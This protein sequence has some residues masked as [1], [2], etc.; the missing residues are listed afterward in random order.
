MDRIDLV[1]PDH[2]ATPV[3]NTKREWKNQ[4][5]IAA[6]TNQSE[7]A[8]KLSQNPRAFTVAHRHGQF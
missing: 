5:G 8:G 6:I 7:R 4:T 2:T 3:Y 1:R